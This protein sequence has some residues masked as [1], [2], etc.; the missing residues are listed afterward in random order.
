MYQLKSLLDG[1]VSDRNPGQPSVSEFDHMVP[2]QTPG[3]GHECRI[4]NHHMYAVDQ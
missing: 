2:L 4:V 1:E 3:R